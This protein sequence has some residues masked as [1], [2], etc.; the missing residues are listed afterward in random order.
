MLV[1]IWLS[2]MLTYSRAA[3][4]FV[5]ILILII[6][7]FLRIGKQL[8]YLIY[9]VLAIVSSFVILSKVTV[10]ADKIAKLLDPASNQGKTLSLWDHLPLT[11]WSLV[12]GIAVLLAAFN[13]LHSSTTITMDRYC[14]QRDL[15]R[16]NGLT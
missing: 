7:P 4:V 13:D 3:L 14:L 12:L 8:L 15:V 2:L 9:T 11:G 10:T 1:P 6:L 16:T 5:P